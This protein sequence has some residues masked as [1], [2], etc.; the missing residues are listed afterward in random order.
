MAPRL[1]SSLTHASLVGVCWFRRKNDSGQENASHASPF[2]ASREPRFN[3]GQQAQTLSSHSPFLPL[4]SKSSGILPHSLDYLMVGFPVGSVVKNLPVNAGDVSS[5]PEKGKIP[6]RRKWQPTSVFL[7]GESNGQ[8]SL[9]GDSSWGHKGLVTT[10]QLSMDV[11]SMIMIII[12]TVIKPLLCTQ[13]NAARRRWGPHLN[14][15]P[16]YGKVIADH[17]DCS[18]GLSPTA[19]KI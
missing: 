2:Q 4:L 11:I 13:E 17:S 19:C 1:G 9:A 16:D 18:S 15:S 5:I 6:W 10:E 14:V 12:D 3:A 7:P 8:R